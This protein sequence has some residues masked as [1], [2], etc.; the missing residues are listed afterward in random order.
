MYVTFFRI[1]DFKTLFLDESNMNNIS[2]SIRTHAIVVNSQ[3][4]NL[5]QNDVF[6][7]NFEML[8]GENKLSVRNRMADCVTSGPRAQWC[9]K[10]IEYT[11]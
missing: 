4:S 7:S 10:L 11:R 1:T 3:T 5:I 8:E 6:Y 9:V 2:Q